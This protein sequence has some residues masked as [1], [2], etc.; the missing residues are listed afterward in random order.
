MMSSG[1]GPVRILGDG[2]EWDARREEAH[3][4]LQ[5]EAHVLT[6]LLL[7]L[8][9]V[10]EADDSPVRA[11]HDLARAVGLVLHDAPHERRLSK[12]ASVAPAIDRSE[13][14]LRPARLGPLG[15]TADATAI[16]KWG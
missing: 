5:T 1:R 7:R 13:T 15:E 2:E 12:P 14:P 11:V 6:R 8:G 9:E 16:S 4:R 3:E 10:V